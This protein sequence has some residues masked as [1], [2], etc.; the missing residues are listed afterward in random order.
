MSS[1]KLYQGDFRERLPK[2]VDAFGPFKMLFAD[3]PD[4]IDWG[5]AGYDDNLDRIKYRDLLYNTISDGTWHSEIFWMSFN[6]NHMNLVG[7]L[8]YMMLGPGGCREGWDCRYIMQYTTFGMNMKGDFSRCFR[9][10]V[11]LMKPGAVTYPDAVRIE[12]ERQRIGDKR[13]DPRGKIPPDVWAI[14]RVTGNSKQRRRWHPTQL[15][16]ALYERCLGFSAQPG[17]RVGDLFAG[18]GTMARAASGRG[19]HVSLFEISPEY[20]KRLSEEHKVP[21]H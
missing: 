8:L 6:V 17:D 10:L 11:R 14:H 4:N 5:Y 2:V 12:S 16:E 21:I 1:L 9:P 20:C 19:L 18:T 7:D 3:P 15:N 13:A